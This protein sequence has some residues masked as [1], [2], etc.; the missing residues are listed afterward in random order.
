MAFF[1]RASESPELGSVLSGFAQDIRLKK[2]KENIKSYGNEMM[3]FVNNLPPE[4]RGD[5][6]ILKA[7]EA[8]IASK[9]EL[10]PADRQIGNQIIQ[11]FMTEQQVQVQRGREKT[12][13]EQEQEDRE[14]RLRREEIKFKEGRED[15]PL[16]KR[17]LETQIKKAETPTGKAE[18][19]TLYHPDGRKVSVK[20]QVAADFYIKQGFSQVDPSGKT[21]IAQE[22][23]KFVNDAVDKFKEEN[24]DATDDQIRQVELAAKTKYKAMLGG[25]EEVTSPDGLP[26]YQKPDGTI[27]D[28]YDNPAKAPVGP[29]EKPREQPEKPI[30]AKEKFKER[31]KAKRRPPEPIS[32]DPAFQSS[33]Q[34]LLKRSG[35]LSS[36]D[37]QKTVKITKGNFNEADN[38]ISFKPKNEDELKRVFRELNKEG[39]LFDATQAA[40]GTITVTVIEKAPKIGF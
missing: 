28:L 8:E 13:F 15:R 29:E 9:Y 23:I 30:S 34:S 32:K 7:G 10:T 2:K 16:R 37:I 5:I 26:H 14:T 11:Q 22:Q 36:P 21:K 31:V 24:F 3:N 39:V 12:R 1:S 40:D 35:A 17:L 19:I 33:I 27:V 6:N 4:Q 25:W 38:T 20:S 18:K